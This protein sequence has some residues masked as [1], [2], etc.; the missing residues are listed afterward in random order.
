ME[1]ILISVEDAII[2]WQLVF[3]V[4]YAVAGIIFLVR[5]FMHWREPDLGRRIAA[6]T[7]LVVGV[8]FALKLV[9]EVG[10]MIDAPHIF[11][12]IA[13]TW[14]A[15]RLQVAAVLFFGGLPILFDMLLTE[16][17]PRTIA[18]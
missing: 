14:D 8:I 1:Q 17:R 18:S 16:R 9:I 7:C 10:V 2:R 12:D 6:V 5:T 15:W 11:T 4:L 13:A 3:L